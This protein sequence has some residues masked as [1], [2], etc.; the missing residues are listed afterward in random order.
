MLLKVSLMLCYLD[1][2][3]VAY[4]GTQQNVMSVNNIKVN[5]LCLYREE[6]QRLEELESTMDASEALENK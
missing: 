6:L 3:I 1:F 4:V 2:F 5:Y